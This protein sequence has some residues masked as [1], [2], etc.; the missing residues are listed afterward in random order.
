MSASR[1][2]WARPA[3]ADSPGAGSV[4]H[5]LLLRT[6]DAR[7]WFVQALVLGITAMHY[8]VEQ[9]PVQ[10][11]VTVV[12]HVPVILY[13]L[14]VVYASLFYGWEG[15]LLTAIWSGLLTLPSI[16]L[17]HRAEFHWLG[18]LTLVTVTLIVGAV[19]AWRVQR[20]TQ[21]RQLAEQAS[22]D[23]ADSENR[24][25]EIFDSAGDPILLFSPDGLVLAANRAAAAATGYSFQELANMPVSTLFGPSG[26]DALLSQFDDPAPSH[27]QLA[28]T[29]RAGAVSLVDVARTGGAGSREQTTQV[30]LRDVTEQE[31]RK[32]EMRAY[33]REVTRA[34]EEERRRIARELHDDTAQSLVLVCRRLETNTGPGE[35]DQTRALVESVLENV[36]RFSRDLRP[37]VLDDLGLLP[38]IE[39]LAAEVSRTSEATVDVSVTGDPQRLRGEAE[40]VL[41]RIAQESLNNVAK[42]AG[43]C[44]ASVTV[45][46]ASEEVSLTVADDGAGFSLPG[47]EGLAGDGKL[48]LLGMRER[49]QLLG[50][51]LSVESEPAR[52]T[53]VRIAVPL[54]GSGG[55]LAD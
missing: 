2:G 15:G 8:T 31:R 33:V 12:H 54:D 47:S 5:Q 30:I 17:T 53:T 3:L 20:E 26:A 28:L 1:A 41:F 39:W 49:A 9:F 51:E 46:F 48:G 29:A 40:L 45:S 43:R 22:R 7:F 27:L 23:L 19:I 6:R 52:G 42:H 18:E 32:K 10:E 4:R 13:L 55:P 37:S 16:T 44:L 21:A 36:R 50:A 34:Q 24:Y 35:I 14:P 11:S 38:A 25:R